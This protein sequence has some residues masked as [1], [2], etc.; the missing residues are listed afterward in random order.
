[1]PYS[2]LAIELVLELMERNDG[3]YLFPAPTVTA[4]CPHQAVPSLNQA[5]RKHLSQLEIAPFTPHDLRRTAATHLGRLG[6]SRFI[7][8]RVLNHVDGSI[9]GVYDRYGYLPEKKAALDRWSTELSSII[10][11]PSPTDMNV[12]R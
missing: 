7:Q 8:D 11:V 2:D 12:T 5:L 3:D 6:V 1:M 10:R 4:K 9:S